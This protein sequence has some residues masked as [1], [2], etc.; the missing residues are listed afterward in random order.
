MKDIFCNSSL[1]KFTEEL[2]AAAPVPGG[3]GAAALCGALAASLCSMAAEITCGNPKYA[4]VQADMRRIADKAD[5]LR[6]RLLADIDRDAAAFHQLSEVYSI[7]KDA[8]KRAALLRERTLNACAAP[9]DM[10][11]DSAAVVELLEEARGKC[12][13]PLLSDV[14][15]AAVFAAAALEAAAMNVFVNTR[16]LKGDAESAKLSCAARETLDEYLPRARA[17]AAAVMEYLTEDG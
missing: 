12:S 8:S 11:R 5:E 13:K 15:C 16:A 4:A 17:A 6:K 2:A 1:S 9:A 14:G 3:G 7:P 10:L